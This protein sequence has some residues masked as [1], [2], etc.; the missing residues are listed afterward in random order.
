MLTASQLDA[1]PDNILKL[2][3]EFEDSVIADIVRRL[4]KMDYATPTAA[5][6]MQRIIES[7]SVY[8]DVLKKLSGFTGKTEKEL[9]DTFS[10]AGVKSMRFDDSVYKAAGLNPLPLNLSPQMA[11][12][13]ANGLRNTN[14]T[15]QNITRSTALSAQRQFLNASDLA[16]M[17]VSSG[18]MSYDQAIKAA[19]QSVGESG[20]GVVY[21]SGRV[22]KLDVAVRRNVLTGVSRTSGDLQMARANEMGQDLVETSAHAGARPAHAQWQGQVFS[23]S[24]TSRKY[25]DFVTSTGYGTATG[26]LGINCRHSFYPFFEGISTA[27]YEKAELESYANKMV[28][29]NGK[30]MTVYEATQEQRAIERQ[31]RS[32]KRQESAL[33]A[34]G[35]DA[36]A[37]AVK[38]R[39]LQEQMRSF[40]RQT[41]LS[42]EYAREGGRVINKTSKVDMNVTGESIS[43][44]WI[45]P[46]KVNT[47]EDLKMKADFSLP[48]DSE[49]FEFFY[50]SVRHASEIDSILKEGLIPPPGGKIFLSKDEIRDR[51]SGVIAI[52][53]PKGLASEGIDHVSEGL[54]YRE[55]T[56]DSAS[57]KD[58]VKVSREVYYIDGGGHGIREDQ[59]AAWAILHPLEDVSSLPAVYRKWFKIAARK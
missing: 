1:V 24:G 39:N 14:G 47:I 25:P 2:Y 40:T 19:V 12:V 37:E 15:L 51:G 35:L 30:K 13:L 45:D 33:Q 54:T 28:T 9:A 50:H 36:S 41:G 38:V 3:H 20:L 21:P 22:D 57:P 46:T 10:A 56:I 55:W 48:V 31:I 49:E 43:E 23:R 59:L 17:Q 58:V 53:V 18:S 6:Q 27:V 16:Y 34:G 32:F 42:R 8:E 11:Q 4:V 52:K 7:G 5:W 26:L 44:V 29:Y